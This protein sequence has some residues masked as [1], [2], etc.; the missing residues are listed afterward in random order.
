MTIGERLY[1]IR[2]DKNFT[3]DYVHKHTGINDKLLFKYEKGIITN[4][5]WD[6]IEVLCDFY[7]VSPKTVMGWDE[8]EAQGYCLNPEVVKIAQEVYNNPE[9]KILFEA[10]K[11]V[12]PEDIKAV[13]DMMMRMRRKEQDDID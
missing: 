5:P 9:L 6:N 12:A 2:K 4:I 3:R 8:E 10:A 13:A 1:E 7:G 11:N